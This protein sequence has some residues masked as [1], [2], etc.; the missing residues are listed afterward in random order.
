MLVMSISLQRCMVLACHC[1]RLPNTALIE[2][3]AVGFAVL[4]IVHITSRRSDNKE[5]G[6][7]C[8][9]KVDGGLLGTRHL[10]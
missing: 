7:S 3:T 8:V 5:H 6:L 4:F 10:M 1:N 2:G 9:R